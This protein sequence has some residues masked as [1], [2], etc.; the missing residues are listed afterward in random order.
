MKLQSDYGQAV[1]WAK[2]FVAQE[3]KA[4][5]DRAAELAKTIGDF[6]ERFAALNGQW[7]LALVRGELRTAR[8]LASAFLPEAENAGR[9][10]EAG[11]THRGLAFMSY[12][13]GD[14]PGA[15]LH[16][17]QA[18][19]TCSSECDLEARER[20][21]EDTRAVAMAMFALAS[22]QLGEVDR[23]RELIEAA[24]RRA[25]EIAHVPSMAVPLHLKSLLEIM[26]GDAAAAL[27]ASESAGG[28]EPGTRD[29]APRNLG[30]N[31]FELGAWSSTRP[32]RRSSKASAGVGGLSRN[33]WR[34][35]YRL[36]SRA[37]GAA[38][39]GGFRH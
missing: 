9:L 15:R 27:T 5:F 37:A 31:E 19:A 25:A 21:G 22:W 35:G 36:L 1:R 7:T 39:G 4:A 18:L 23:A 38:R 2:G 3:T 6:S 26:R 8:E 29:G 34:S 20:S 32:Q 10:M 14:F 16:C 12:F 11:V 13:A 17:E 28:P 30:R 24:N 33:R